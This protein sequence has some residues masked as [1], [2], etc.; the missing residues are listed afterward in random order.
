LPS[1]RLAKANSE[2]DLANLPLDSD[3]TGMMKESQPPTTKVTSDLKRVVYEYQSNIMSN[4]K[5]R[6]A[7]IAVAT[8]VISG[9]SWLCK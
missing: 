6:I 5:T 2:D 4:H 9:R 3:L 7:V 8:A 1:I